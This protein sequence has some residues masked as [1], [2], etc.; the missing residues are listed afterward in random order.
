M[1]I[2]PG[3]KVQAQCSHCRNAF[4]AP[5]DLAGAIT[6]CPRCGKS[7]EVPGQNDPMWRA[8]QLFAMLVAAALGI[9]ASLAW[10]P[11]AGIGI[12]IGVAGLLWL[13][14]RAM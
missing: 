7:V 4:E 8:L 9:M 10:G 11:L 13:A 14:S 12:A 3:Q 5:A 2:N 1:N 6:N